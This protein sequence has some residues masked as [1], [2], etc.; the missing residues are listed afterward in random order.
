VGRQLTGKPG[1]L[2]DKRAKVSLDPEHMPYRRNYFGT[3]FGSP[4]LE[5]VNGY[6]KSGLVRLR[7]SEVYSAC[8]RNE[9]RKIYG[10]K[11]PS[12]CKVTSP[13]SVSRLSR[14]YGNLNISQPY[15]LPRPVTGIAL[16]YGDKV[17]P[18]R[19]ELDCKYCYK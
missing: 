13:P 12:A 17:L 16:L 9:Y 4:G 19:Y 10:G 1:L 2:G 3:E 11:E 7:G 15:R 14:Q 5:A 18:V 6:C 8:N